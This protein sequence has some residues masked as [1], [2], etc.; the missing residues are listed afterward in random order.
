MKNSYKIILIAVALIFGIT[1][2]NAQSSPVTF[3]VK[4]GLN[5]SNLDISGGGFTMDTDPK[6]G[7]NVGLT[8]DYALPANFYILSGLELTT[9][10]ADFDEHGVKFDP[11]LMYL[12]MP[13]NAGYKLQVM[14]NLKILF[15]AGP[16]FAY[17]IGGKTKVS[18]YDEWGDYYSGKYDS[19]GSEGWAKRFDMGINGG[20]GIEYNKFV[21]TIGCDYGVI[22]INDGSGDA[23]TQNVSFTVGYKF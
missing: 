6:I 17:G 2:V 15:F 8:V 1:A 16:Y 22:D 21:A 7:F 19:F 5:I 11:N 23:Y 12:Q 9:K 20:A 14:D 10:G 4:G 18:G 3:G 13:I